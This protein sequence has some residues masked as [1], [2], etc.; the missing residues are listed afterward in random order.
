M[1]SEVVIVRV[2]LVGGTV[3]TPETVLPGRTL[4][5]KY[6]TLATV[7][8]GFASLLTLGP[9]TFTASGKGRAGQVRAGGYTPCP[10]TLPGK[11]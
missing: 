2:L 6:L 8:K 3:R 4:G 7:S 1:Q 5:V 9:G 10:P 11:R